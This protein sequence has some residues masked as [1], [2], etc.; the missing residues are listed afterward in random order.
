MTYSVLM[1]TLNPTHTLTHSLTRIERPNSAW[2]HM[3]RR[4]VFLGAIHAPSQVEG[5][6]HPPNFSG[7]PTHFDRAAVSPMWNHAQ[8]SVSANA[9]SHMRHQL[10]GTV[11]R[12]HCINSLTPQCLSGGW[13]PNFFSKH[14]I[15]S[16]LNYAILV[17]FLFPFLCFITSSF[18]ISCVCY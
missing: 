4:S 16:I 10:L 13:N 15:T 7:P 2:Y 14:F 1:G 18:Y 17:F 3:S 8:D 5:L 9:L 11:C 6:Q 12:L